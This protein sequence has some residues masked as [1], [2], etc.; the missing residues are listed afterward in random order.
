MEEREGVKLKIVAPRGRFISA[1]DLIGAMTPRTR[2]VSVSLV[3]YDD[4]S[5][6]DAPRVAAACHK[7]GALLLLDVSQCCG[8]MPMNVHKLGADFLVWR[9]VQASGHQNSKLK[10]CPSLEPPSIRKG[11][12]NLSSTFKDGKLT[13]PLLL[14]LASIL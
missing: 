13:E 14:R 10:N 8:A 1:D 6:L 11:L 5:L 12:G 3:R 4:G 7:Q 2:V 9:W